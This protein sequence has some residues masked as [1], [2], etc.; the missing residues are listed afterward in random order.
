[1]R[2]AAGL[3]LAFSLSMHEEIKLS[4]EVSAVQIPSGDSMTLPAGTYRVAVMFPGHEAVV[5][6]VEVRWGHVEHGHDGCTTGLPQPVQAG[7]L[8]REVARGCV[9]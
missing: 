7:R 1:M 8:P 4:R 3:M 9:R 5:R 6:E 2:L